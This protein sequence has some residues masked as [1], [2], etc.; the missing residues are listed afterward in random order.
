MTTVYN[1]NGVAFDIDA[2]ATDLNGKC[3]KDGVNATF[4]HIVETHHG[5][6]GWYRVYS[7]GWCEQGGYYA[8]STSSVKDFVFLKPFVNNDYFLEQG[9]AY[10]S[11]H[12]YNS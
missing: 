4:I 8:N 6:D 11:F 2:I 1:K 9:Y 7:D 10:R 3:D 12:H 5:D